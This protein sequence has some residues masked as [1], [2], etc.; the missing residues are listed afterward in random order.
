ME[1]MGIAGIMQ[2]SYT[3][4]IGDKVKENGKY[5]NGLYRGCIGLLLMKL[6]FVTIFC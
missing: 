6:N 1:T 5:Y 4:Y 3:G 2:G